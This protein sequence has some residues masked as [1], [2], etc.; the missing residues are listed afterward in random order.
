MAAKADA[1]NTPADEIWYSEA[2]ALLA[3]R[4]GGAVD[5]AERQLLKGLK[6]GMPWSHLQKD[7]T[8]VKEDTAFWQQTGFLRINRLE[9]SAG[10]ADFIVGTVFWPSGGRAGHFEPATSDLPVDVFGIKVS[11]TA[12]LALIPAEPADHRS[13]TDW[14]AT[15][16][17]DTAVITATFAAKGKKKGRAQLRIFEAA[18]ELWPPNGIV[19]LDVD[20]AGLQH[21][22]EGL[23]K[24]KAE[25]RSAASGK[26]EKPPDPPSWPSC[27]RFLMDQRGT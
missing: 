5:F 3:A 20:P 2:V 15:E 17:A 7:G 26:K 19:P 1:E 14:I 11:R 4:C 27:K 9:N 23:D 16:A 13:T 12:A 6:E 18:R 8:R 25:A 10:Y 22:I 24:R 21:A